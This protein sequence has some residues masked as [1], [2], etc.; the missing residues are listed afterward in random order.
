MSRLRLSRFDGSV[1]D[2]AFRLDS[3][4][5]YKYGLSVV[6]G[7]SAFLFADGIFMISLLNSILQNAN[8][9]ELTK[10]PSCNS[11]TLPPG[12]LNVKGYGG[13]KKTPSC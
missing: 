12:K 8:S 4:L 6:I 7:N 10:T 3:L 11:E 13:R 2:E 1:F 9:I 5:H